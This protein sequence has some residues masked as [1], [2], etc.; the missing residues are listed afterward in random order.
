MKAEIRIISQT[1]LAD[2][3]K[4]PIGQPRLKVHGSAVV[5][6]PEPIGLND[7]K[8]CMR[9]WMDSYARIL[10]QDPSAVIKIVPF[11]EEPKL[12]F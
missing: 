3:S 8:V 12:P 11:V 10:R 6:M 5:T 2:P 9:V 7:W 1:L 4:L